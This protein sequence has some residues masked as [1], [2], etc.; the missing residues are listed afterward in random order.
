MGEITYN[1]TG[2]YTNMIQATTIFDGC[3]YVGVGATVEEATA[4][5]L[6][7]FTAFNT[8]G[9]THARKTRRR[10]RRHVSARKS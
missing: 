3:R 5:L 4:S 2:S 1:L 6:A 9:R 10:K 7:S 8:K